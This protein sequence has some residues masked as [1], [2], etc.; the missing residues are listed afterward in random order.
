MYHMFKHVPRYQIIIFPS[1]AGCQYRISQP[2]ESPINTSNGDTFGVWFI[3]SST[4]TA[5]IIESI[6]WGPQTMASHHFG[7]QFTKGGSLSHGRPPVSEANIGAWTVKQELSWWL[8]IYFGDHTTN[9][10]YIRKRKKICCDSS[11]ML[12]RDIGWSRGHSGN[13]TWEI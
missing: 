12:C 8:F 5:S 3:S 6:R 1:V 13:Q 10:T 2:G 9:T 7:H 11:V 4:F